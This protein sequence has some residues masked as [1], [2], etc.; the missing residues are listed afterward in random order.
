MNLTN[1]PI[2]HLEHR[3]PTRISRQYDASRRYEDPGTTSQEI[4]NRIERNYE[5][6]VDTRDRSIDV[7]QRLER[8]E[9]ILLGNHNDGSNGDGGDHRQMKKLARTGHSEQPQAQLQPPYDNPFYTNLGPSYESPSQSHI[10]PNGSMRSNATA[11][12]SYN[13]A[14][15]P[16]PIS[17]KHNH[18]PN[19]GRISHEKYYGPSAL[20]T[21][22]K[23]PV[24]LIPDD[25][26]VSRNQ[27][28]NVTRSF[29]LS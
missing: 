16:H 8:V 9:R 25:Q 19:H 5:V 20:F 14:T 18:N 29:S 24:V 12:S 1:Q 15:V 7:Q 2:F 17:A 23:P 6:A 28:D 10:P 27:H 22:D 4:Q 26:T 11:G 3:V 13:A 21:V